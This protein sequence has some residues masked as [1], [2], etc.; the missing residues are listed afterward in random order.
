[1]EKYITFYLSDRIA[2]RESQRERGIR[3]GVMGLLT[4][5]ALLKLCVM[6]RI[7]GSVP[8]QGR[9]ISAVPIG[10]KS[11]ASAGRAFHHDMASLHAALSRELRGARS[12]EWAM[13]T[14]YHALQPLMDAAE[15]RPA[16]AAGSY[17]SL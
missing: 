10:G 8:F 15:V 13:T 7:A 4:M 2:V 17:L 3:E 6:T 11:V 12:H 14:I 16:P 9:R 1:R 5:L